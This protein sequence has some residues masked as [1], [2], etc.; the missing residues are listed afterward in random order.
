MALKA[1]FI[2][3]LAAAGFLGFAQPS[4][5][6]A[7]PFGAADDCQGLAQGATTSKA[8]LAPRPFDAAQIPGSP[9]FTFATDT[10][11]T[12]T[13]VACQPKI[14]NARPA[15]P[16]GLNAYQANF[17]HA[18]WDGY[19]NPF[20]CVEL[21]ARYDWLRWHDTGQDGNRWVWGNAAENWTRHP[22]H[23]ARK[24]NGGGTA[25]VAGDILIWNDNG[26]GHIAV[27]ADVDG[28]ARAATILEQNFS[29]AYARTPGKFIWYTAKR[30]LSFE[31][32]HEDGVTRY[33]FTGAYKAWR[34]DGTTFTGRD[35][36]PVG[37]LHG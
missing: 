30:E 23:F 36:R 33:T 9:A 3:T 14:V 16:F 6:A 2:F 35:A 21:I 13:L 34:Q 17:N 32:A 8:N 37:W 27:I 29:Y 4:H 20:Q 26:Y 11:A 31:V 28:S 10:G 24:V 25:P 1:C 19:G 5:A 12:A 18:T 7:R 15:A 22:A